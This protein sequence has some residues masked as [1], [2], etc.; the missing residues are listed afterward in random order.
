LDARLTGKFSEDE[1]NNLEYQFRVIY[2]FDSA[3]KSK[4]H[5][6]FVHPGT[7]EAEQIKSVLVKYAAGDDLFPHKPSVVAKLVSKRA[8]TKFTTNDHSKAWR[9]FKVRPAPGSKKPHETNRDY[10][11]YHAAHGDY[12]YSDKWVEFLVDKASDKE[13]LSSIR[14]QEQK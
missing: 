7:P 14:K 1:R 8:K 4:S 9:F 6:Q 10:C 5:I 2:T 12:T 3:S 13:I 11:M